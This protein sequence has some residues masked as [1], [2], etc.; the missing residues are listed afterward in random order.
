M[1]SQVYSL[2]REY[3]LPKKWNNVRREFDEIHPWVQ[4]P[5]C[6]MPNFVPDHET[7]LGIIIC[8]DERRCQKDIATTQ[9]TLGK[10][11]KQPI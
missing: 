3:A 6:M 2:A 1:L 7:H 10:C 8:L 5:G 4:M 11:I 9:D